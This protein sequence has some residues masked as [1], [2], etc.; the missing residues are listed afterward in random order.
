MSC[1]RLYKK[2]ALKHENELRFF[3]FTLYQSVMKS[4]QPVFSRD[5]PD[6][7]YLNRQPLSNYSNACS[8]VLIKNGDDALT[9]PNIKLY[10]FHSGIS[11][12][13]AS[14]F[15]QTMISIGDCVVIRQLSIRKFDELMNLSK[16]I[17]NALP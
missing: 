16:Q 4:L 9:H 15:S 10:C 6:F 1:K 2:K 3:K 5:I 11:E 17:D 13:Q 12:R 14:G 7:P 8:R